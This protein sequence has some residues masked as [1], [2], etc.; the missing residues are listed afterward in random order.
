MFK[1]FGDDRGGSLCAM[2]TF[3]GFLSLFPLLLLLVTVLGFF[4]GTEHS[5]VHRVEVSAFAE[6]PIVGTKL[7]SNIHGLQGR[8]VLG[9]VGD[10]RGG[11]GLP[12]RAADGAVRAGG[13]LEHSGVNRPSFWARLGRTATA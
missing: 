1:K 10:R 7:S 6:F 3:Y 4:G 9:L 11:L 2:L 12:R 8:S 13:G 5:F